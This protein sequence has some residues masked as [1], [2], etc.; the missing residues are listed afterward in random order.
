MKKLK[1]VPDFKNKDQETKFWESHD[2]TDYVDWSKAGK[3]N[4]PNLKPSTKTISI[5]LPVYLLENIKKQ[6]NKRDIPYQSL[7]KVYLSK[8]VNTVE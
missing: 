3:A 5:R 6:A 8:A 2:S 7:M 1:E 4:F